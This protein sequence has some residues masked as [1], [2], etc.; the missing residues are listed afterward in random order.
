[1]WLGDNGETRVSKEKIKK[2]KREDLRRGKI[3]EI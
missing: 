1:M 3:S 2:E